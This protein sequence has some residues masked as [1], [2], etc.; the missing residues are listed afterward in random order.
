MNLV[1]SVD[2]FEEFEYHTFDLRS[3][4]QDFWSDSVVKLMFE[5]CER[6]VFGQGARLFSWRSASGILPR[7][8]PHGRRGSAQG[9]GRRRRDRRN[10]RKG[11][12][13][14][15]ESQ[16]TDTQANDMDD[17]VDEVKRARADTWANV[18]C[19]TL[20]STRIVHRKSDVWGVLS[21]HAVGYSRLL[22]AVNETYCNKQL[23][24]W[25]ELMSSTSFWTCPSSTRN[26]LRK[27]G[28]IFDIVEKEWVLHVLRLILGG[29]G[30]WLWLQ[31]G[32]L[33]E[34]A[35]VHSYPICS[36]WDIPVFPISLV[37][38]RGWAVGVVFLC[39]LIH[40]DAFLLGPVNV[41]LRITIYILGLEENFREFHR[42]V[43][44]GRQLFCDI[45]SP[46]WRGYGTVS[47]LQF[48]RAEHHGVA[49]SWLR[50]AG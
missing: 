24:K 44:P 50:S 40:L 6:G 30:F 5:L 19:N 35:L 49:P 18:L 15:T 25:F 28:A 27:K 7:W 45:F 39:Q 16:R 20:F 31:L 9:S 47:V 11:T 26:H 23:K 21:T 43:L 14:G 13:W 12:M 46:C 41:E 10:T 38:L 3:L 17:H 48:Y 36:M 37:F 22:S 4:L 34:V 42:N 32:S 8:R 1:L 33:I 29:D 2:L